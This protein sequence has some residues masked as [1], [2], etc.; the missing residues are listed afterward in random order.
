[1]SS[2]LLRPPAVL[3]ALLVVSAAV[4]ATGES[5]L[6]DAA[7][8][9]DQK[10]IR[11]LLT[12]RADV[13]GQSEDGTTALLWAAHWNDLETADLLIRAGADVNLANHLRMTPLSLACTN[14]N[15]ALVDRL[16]TAGANPNTA[17]ATGETPVMTCASAGSADAVRLLVAR[18][19]DV[20]AREPVQNQTALMWAAAEGHPDVVR[21]L[22]EH[23]A[24]LQARTK[25]GFTALHFAAREGDIESARLLLA[26]GVDV[27]IQSQPEVAEKRGSAG[28]PGYRAGPS[29]SGGPS[30]E[31]SVSAGSTPLL[32]ATVR[33]QVPLALFLIEQGADPNAGAA[34]FTPLHWAAG[35][36]EGGEANPVFGF[37]DAMSGI[38]NRQAKL[39]LV[40]ALLAHGADPNARMS[41]RPPGFAA[42]FTDVV[43]ATPFL[44]ASAT[45]DVEVMRLLLAKGADAKAVTKAGTTAIM[46]ATGMNRTI[47][48]SAV[49]EAQALETV[50]LLLEL[51][52]DAKALAANG[53]NA[54]F[55]PSYRGWNTLLQLLID[56]GADVNAM[57]KASITPWLAASG[58]GDRLGGVLFNPDTAALLVKHGADPKLGK[59]CMAQTKCR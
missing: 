35:T 11:A 46:A 38:P 7:R 19:A 21:L 49:T 36:W 55:G 29:R 4:T 57:S 32:V 42:G 12:E 56:Q 10:A 3:A 44:L 25:K 28:E 58:L 18:G 24:D 54:L 31:A 39:D 26:A 1:M 34:G 59:P 23:R 30:Y 13:N 20:N 14:R 9:R 15:A 45:A 52:V 22:I 17:I 41:R 37:S 48:E 6:V 5:R 53:E 50:K 47:G 33:A 43:G 8:N 51:G 27:N 16:L 40:N 2:A